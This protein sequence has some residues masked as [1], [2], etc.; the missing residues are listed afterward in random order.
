MVGTAATRADGRVLRA[1]RH[2]HL[3]NVMLTG[4][5]HESVRRTARVSARLQSRTTLAATR[6]VGLLVATD[7]EGGL[8]QVLQGPGF[9]AMPTALTQGRWGLGRLHDRA[10]RWGHQLHRAGVTMNLAPVV[11]TVPGPR[12]ARHNPPIGAYDR[13]FGYTTRVVARHGRAFLLGMHRQ[14]RGAGRQALPGPRP[15]ARQPR[16][17]AG[18]DRQGHPPPRPLPAAVRDRR[19]RRRPGRDDVDRDLPTDRPRHAGRLLPRDRHRHAARRPRLPARRRL[20]RPRQRRAG[21]ALA[22]RRPRR[23]VP[24]RRR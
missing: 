10:A 24:P 15:R 13:E 16:H 3:G 2:R 21:L 4:R 18:R 7:Q 12:A 6:R 19:P 20:R 8:V 11:D 23:D 22:P 14:R 17:D 9:D 1:I 5:S